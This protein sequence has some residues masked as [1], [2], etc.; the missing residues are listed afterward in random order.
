MQSTR[1]YK[2]KFLLLIIFQ[3]G[4]ILTSSLTQSTTAFTSF[5][6][7]DANDLNDLNAKGNA[8]SDLGNNTEAVRYL[9]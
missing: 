5:T 1:A 8:L 3:V 9:R 4:F 7:T 2:R 6:N